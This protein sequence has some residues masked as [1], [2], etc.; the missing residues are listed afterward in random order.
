MSAKKQVTAVSSRIDVCERRRRQSEGRCAIIE[1][2]RSMLHLALVVREKRRR[3][4]RRPRCHALG[5]MAQG[6]HLAP[7]RAGSQ[8]LTEAFRT[9]VSEER[10][11]GAR[12][13]IALGGEY[14]VTRVI[15]GPTEDVRREFAEL[16][17]RSLRYLTLGPGPKALAGSTQQL[18]ARHQHALLAVANQRTLDQ[19]MQIADAVGLQI[20]SIEPSLIAL[21][22]AKRNSR[23]LQRGRIIIQLDEDVAELGI[24]HNGRMLLD[25]RPGGRTNAENVAGVVAQ[26]FSRLQR[27]IE[28]YHSYLDAPLRHV[29]LAGDADAVARARTKVRRACQISRSTCWSRRTSTCPG[30]T[31]PR[32]RAPIWPPRSA[33]PWIYTP[34]RRK[35]RART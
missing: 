22:R 35:N 13:R 23:R 28:R 33:R 1:V 14:C 20:E 29:Y 25:Y 24:C 17:E 3:Y 27:Y 6:G 7:H 18:D 16:E 10:I 12:V 26:H 9:L 19:L 31:R 34:I 8:E 21:S 11:G 4:R 2:C 32:R 30:T 15:T 5:S